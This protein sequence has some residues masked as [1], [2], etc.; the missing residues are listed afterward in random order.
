[1]LYHSAI[2]FG[3]YVQ[4]VRKM[5]SERRRVGSAGRAWMRIDDAAQLR[6]SYASVTPQ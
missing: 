6:L 3:L 2:R 1:M 4:T 5:R